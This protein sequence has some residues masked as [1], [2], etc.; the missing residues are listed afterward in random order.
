MSYAVF[1]NSKFTRTRWCA[2]LK[3]DAIATYIG[4]KLGVPSNLRTTPEE[5]N[6]HPTKYAD[7]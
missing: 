5:N 4:D 1:P 7:V 3:P 2:E 6:N